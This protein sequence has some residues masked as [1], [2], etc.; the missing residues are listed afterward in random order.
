VNPRADRDRLPPA[1]SGGG[2][3]RWALLALLACL[4]LA[5]SPGTYDPTLA[6]T[7]A[8]WLL[9]AAAWAALAWCAVRSGGLLPAWRRLDGWSCA[10][11]LV[12]TALATASPWPWFAWPAVRDAGLLG[13]VYWAVRLTLSPAD[14]PAVGRTLAAV[15]CLAGG[16]GL[17]QTLVP[18]WAGLSFTAPEGWPGRGM[19][20]TMG[21]P[22]FLACWLLVA[23]P[24]AVWPAGA[25]SASGP[26][27]T[28]RPGTRRLLAGAV[29]AFTLAC[30]GLTLSRAAWLALAVEL[31]LLGGL[32]AWAR[33]REVWLAGAATALV[34]ALAPGLS[35]KLWSSGTLLQ[36]AAIWEGAL[37]LVAERPLTGCGPGSFGA[38][39]P[40][41]RPAGFRATRLPF[42]NDY[43]HD[44]AL[45]AAAA[46]G[47]VGV[48]LLLS[49]LASLWLDGGPL[50]ARHVAL[51][52]VLVQNLFSVT[53]CV[54]PLAV[55]AAFV[56]AL[57][58]RGG[59]RPG[60]RPVRWLAAP[61]LLLALAAAGGGWAAR[62]DGQAS[63]LLREARRLM[64]LTGP[65]ASAERAGAVLETALERRPFWPA[66]RYRRTGLRAVAGD[67]TGAAAGYV[68]LDAIS[69][70][71]AELPANRAEVYLAMGRLEA[72]GRQA[73][74]WEDMNSADPASH[75][76]A[77]KVSEAR[78]DLREALESALQARECGGRGE[79][80]DSMLR[81]LSSSA[82][83]G[84]RDR[85]ADSAE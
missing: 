50:E 32:P 38:A 45:H 58:S 53:L 81:R 13:L 47:V 25:A 70:A 40:A 9:A 12:W 21:N 20:S 11:L 78:G 56:A 19:A 68:L 31:A 10:A 63:A 15:T 60:P 41:Q 77:A 48:L 28:A 8:A 72:A 67:L 79:A 29:V 85:A 44:L 5:F 65:A 22:D 33:R 83:L 84:S 34:L 24:F 73:R 16:A 2:V 46:G 1:P 49:G 42:V 82:A 36:R 18:G 61:A 17:I 27:P 39:F 23:L 66:S 71:Y 74:L 7:T 57:P 76:L 14:L 37:G 69:P 62:A 80:L 54:T 3:A 6:K 75:V 4:G 35:A 26:G 30:L 64:D 55:L 43:A 51:A 59:V 52:G